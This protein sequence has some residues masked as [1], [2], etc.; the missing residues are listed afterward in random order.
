[1]AISSET[2]LH[3]LYIEFSSLFS[4][5]CVLGG[6]GKGG[7][8]TENTCIAEQFLILSGLNI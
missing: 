8:G 3:V 1:M 6:W 4:F 2:E 5:V 7:G